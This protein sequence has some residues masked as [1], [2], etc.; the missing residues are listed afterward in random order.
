MMASKANVKHL[1]L[2]HM[3]PNI[4]QKSEQRKSLKEMKKIFPGKITFSNE[5]D[6]IFL[7]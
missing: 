6:E 3:G 5:L 7:D 1:V 2:T 4:N